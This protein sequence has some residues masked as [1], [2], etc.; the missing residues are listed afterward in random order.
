MPFGQSIMSITQAGGGFGGLG[1]FPTPGGS[2]SSGSGG[3]GF[4]DILNT[5]VG[6]AG[7]ILAARNV[8]PPVFQSTSGGLTGGVAAP[9]VPAVVRAGAGAAARSP[10]VQGALGGLAGSMLPDFLGGGSSGGAGLAG[11]RLSSRTPRGN[12]TNAIWLDRSFDDQLVFWK[13]V[14]PK[15]WQTTG[16]TRITG[17]TGRRTC[18]PR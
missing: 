15:G 4:L 8:A 17:S 10:V 11:V 13:R 12:P 3:A 2:A 5:A 6:A 18:R 7:Q 14:K 1:G 16:S 9:F